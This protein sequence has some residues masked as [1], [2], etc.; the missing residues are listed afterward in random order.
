MGQTGRGCPKSRF[1]Y[2]VA[3]G[4]VSAGIEGR[5]KAPYARLGDALM[6]SV[7]H[8]LGVANLW[9][10]LGPELPQCG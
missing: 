5:R 4:L 10:S 9:D 8:H 7:S 1:F 2:R 3:A 6:N